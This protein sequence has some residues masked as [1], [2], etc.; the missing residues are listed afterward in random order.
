VS[1]PGVQVPLAISYQ[2][3]LMLLR[4]LLVSVFLFSTL[5]NNVCFASDMGG[6]VHDMVVFD[7]FQEMSCCDADLFD[8]A[9]LAHVLS[10]HTA[11]LIPEGEL[12]F[13]KEVR[14]LRA[15]SPSFSTLPVMLTG[16]IF[17]LE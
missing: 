5:L 14:L 15:L 9:G 4:Y 8:E 17:K 1:T 13:A 3:R 7:E 6:S 2:Q 16:V 11:N 12:K 10:F